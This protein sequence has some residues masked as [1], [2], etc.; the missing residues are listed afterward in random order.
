M[1]SIYTIF[2]IL[3]L[4]SCADK[5]E[6]IFPEKKSITESVYASGYVKSK[7]QY[8]VYSKVNGIVEY[9]FVASGDTVVNGEPIISVY[10][11]TQK[12]NNENAALTVNY[13]NYNS[14]SEQLNELKNRIEI[15]REKMAIDSIQYKRQI[16]LNEKNL[17]S[18]LE[19]ENK[20]LAFKNSK[21]LYLSALTQYKEF[22]R[23]LNYNSAQ[24]RKN[25][26]ITGEVEKDFTVFSEIKGKV[27]SLEVEKGEMV[28]IQSPI[29]VIG[30]AKRFILE[31]EIDERDI[32]KTV[33]GLPVVIELDSYKNE[34][35]D[36]VITKVNPLMNIKNR[37][38][39]V[40]AEFVNPPNVLYPNLN[41]QANI[42]VNS[43]MEALLIPREYIINDSFVITKNND[44]IPVVIGL[45]DF[46]FAEILKGITLKDE[47][48]KP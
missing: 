12:I 1:K 14:N 48:I 16:K 2:A 35:F 40:E 9:L 43:R 39:V 18:S 7:N 3:L 37:S 19:L 27:Y 29:A 17:G 13:Y 21:S 11:K 15:A 42:I 30:D 28:N 25:R 26:L 8:T 31:M 45:K 36:A 41:F 44:T 32:L 10:N 33:V 22:K 5:Q 23:Q 6:S 24:A 38:F 4:T 46:Q 47:L 34:S 20:E